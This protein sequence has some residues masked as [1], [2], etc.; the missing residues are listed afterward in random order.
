[1]A[2]RNSSRGFT[3]Q[4]LAAASDPLHSP[5][6]SGE[7]TGPGHLVEVTLLWNTFRLPSGPGPKSDQ[8]LLPWSLRPSHVFNF[9][10]FIS[11]KIVTLASVDQ[12]DQNPFLSVITTVSC[13]NMVPFLKGSWP[14]KPSHNSL[15][16]RMNL[17]TGNTLFTFASWIPEKAGKV[18]K[19]LLHF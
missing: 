3:V 10:E 1:M 17:G 19:A 14:V 7:H 9:I 15:H 18:L 2:K 16:R 5:P 11:F 8:L 12:C 4:L 6:C 13:I